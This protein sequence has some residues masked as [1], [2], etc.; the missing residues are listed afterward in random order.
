[1]KVASRDIGECC[2]DYL[3]NGSMV[4]ARDFEGMRGRIFDARW[5]INLDVDLFPPIS[6]PRRITRGSFIETLILAVGIKSMKVIPREVWGV[7]DFVD[8]ARGFRFRFL[9]AASIEPGHNVI[10]SHIRKRP[11]RR[12]W[13]R[14]EWIMLSCE[15]SEPFLVEWEIGEVLDLH[16]RIRIV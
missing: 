14:I 5:N 13:G 12:G 6:S 8:E 10:Y 16:V 7:N 11:R 9:V 2:L 15:G 3:H 1:M 4:E